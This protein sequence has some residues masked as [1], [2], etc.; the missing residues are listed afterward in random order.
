MFE[1]QNR[2][3]LQALVKE[4]PGE[5]K[6]GDTMS[7]LE[8]WDQLE[9]QEAPF[10]IL[11][12]EEDMGIKANLGRPGAREAWQAALKGLAN[13]QDNFFLSGSQI[14]V[15][16]RFRFEQWQ[17]EADALDPNDPEQLPQLRALTAQVDAVVP[18][19]I[20]RIKAAGKVPIIIGGGH[21]NAYGIIRGCSEHLSKGL[22]VLNI[23][24]HADLRAD[25]GRHSGNGFRHAF[26]EGWLARYAVFGLEEGA[27]NR[28]MIDLFHETPQLYYLSSDELLTFSTQE[29]DKLFKDAL[30]WLGTEAIGLELDCDALD[31]FPASA[32]NPA[33]F[34]LRQARLMVKTAAA[35]RPP[36]YFHLPEAA[37]SLAPDAT[38]ASAVGKVLALL[39]ADFI[40]AYGKG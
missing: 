38:T 23:D 17:K 10:V 13:V 7:V 32:Y 4:R 26:K 29:R 15:A 8:G 40:K 34:T 1:F 20:K 18:P 28:E 19:I 31:R 36:H 16:G 39:V 37:P 30:H 5:Q 24:P 2:E 33:G 6:L 27:N 14:L 12:I 35:L 11:G 9:Q 21:N 3:A 25:E 22:A